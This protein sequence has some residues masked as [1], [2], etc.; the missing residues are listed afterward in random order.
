MMPILCFSQYEKTNQSN[1]NLNVTATYKPTAEVGEGIK[2]RGNGVFTIQKTDSEGWHGFNWLCEK[3]E[4][5]IAEL[6]KNYNCIYSIINKEKSKIQKFSAQAVTRAVIR[7]A[8][9]SGRG[10]VTSQ[11]SRRVTRWAVVG[12]PRSAARAPPSA[13]ISSPASSSTP[14]SGHLSKPWTS[15][16]CRSVG[17]FCLSTARAWQT[18]RCSRGSRRTQ[19][20][21]LGCG[22]TRWVRG[23][24]RRGVGWC[25]GILA[26]QWVYSHRSVQS[27]GSSLTSFLTSVL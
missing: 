4:K 21:W 20:S 17:N 5:E 13:R 23:R 26:S 3:A 16:W 7:S 11:T 18:R 24:V 12:A 6:A 27:L 9:R 1:N 15:R 2:Y 8:T 22:K 25:V 10:A 19:V 14:G